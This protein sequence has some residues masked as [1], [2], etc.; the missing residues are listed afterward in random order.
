MNL[1]KPEGEL[2][3]DWEGEI[4]GMM[5][6]PSPLC[7]IATAACEFSQAPE[8]TALRKFRDV[9]LHRSRAGRAF[10]RA[11]YRLSPPI[12]GFVSRSE[13]IRKIVYKFVVKP[14]SEIARHL[15]TRHYRALYYKRSR[16]NGN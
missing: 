2:E 12:A 8:V 4:M 11:Y 14:L 16:D 10:V 13:I 3:L 5:I 9:I 7:F 15:L 6:P 1:E